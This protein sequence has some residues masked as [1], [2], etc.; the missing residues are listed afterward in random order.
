MIKLRLFWWG[1][2]PG[3]FGWALNVITSVPI[4]E[5]Q[6]EIRQQNRSWGDDGNRDW[7]DALWKCRREPQAKEFR[8][9]LETEKGKEIDSSLK[10]SEK[11]QHYQHLNF[12]LVKLILDFWLS[13]L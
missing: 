13:E 8:Q 3:F 12:N 10:D 7:S 11:N 9:E 4:G 2:Y 6:R 1:E 5:R